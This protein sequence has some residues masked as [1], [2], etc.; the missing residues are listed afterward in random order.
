LAKTFALSKRGNRK[1]GGIPVGACSRVAIARDF[2]PDKAS[3]SAHE[4]SDTGATIPFAYSS[5]K[6]RHAEALSSHAIAI[7]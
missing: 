4:E 3:A 6:R 2:W 1:M 5:L 7:F